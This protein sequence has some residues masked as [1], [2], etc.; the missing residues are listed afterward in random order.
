MVQGPAPY[1]TSSNKGTALTPTSPAKAW[2]K[3][4]SSCFKSCKADKKCGG[5]IINLATQTCDYYS[6]PSCVH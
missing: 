2:D 1:K 3:F 5:L 6:V 4:L